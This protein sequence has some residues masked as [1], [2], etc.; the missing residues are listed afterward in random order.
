MQI[1]RCYVLQRDRVIH[2]K[3]DDGVGTD[4]VHRRLHG[5]EVCEHAAVEL[6]VIAMAEIGDDILA[7]AGTEHE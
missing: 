4:L 6:D 3:A 5:L 7:E 1:A 2:V